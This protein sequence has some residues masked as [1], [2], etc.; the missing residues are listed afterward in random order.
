MDM[1][2]QKKLKKAFEGS[3]YVPLKAFIF[4]AKGHVMKRMTCCLLALFLFGCATALEQTT[5]GVPE[6]EKIQKIAIVTYPT[7]DE[8]SI[9]N[10]IE[11]TAKFAD[12]FGVVGLLLDW[13]MLNAEEKASLGGDPAVLKD[14]IGLFPVKKHIDDYLNEQFSKAYQIVEPNHADILLKV[15][16]VYGLAIYS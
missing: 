6:A 8:F 16:F 10:H 15:D 2:C 7:E 14:L 12:G 13:A 3:P 1:G 11:S 4:Y 5:P 9:L